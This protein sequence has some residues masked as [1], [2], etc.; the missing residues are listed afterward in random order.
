MAS[1]RNAHNEIV[2][3]TLSIN[4]KIA[5]INPFRCFYVYYR[6]VVFYT[7]AHLKRRLNNDKNKQKYKNLVSIRLE[8]DMKFKKLLLYKMRRVVFLY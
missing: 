6:V 7:F 8:T 5:H 2:E 3:K 1:Y 4:S